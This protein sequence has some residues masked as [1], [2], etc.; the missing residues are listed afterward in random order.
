MRQIGDEVYGAIWFDP[1][2]TGSRL[3]AAEQVKKVLDDYARD[4]N[5]TLSKPAYREM[6]PGE[7]GV[8]Q[9]PRPNVLLYYGSARIVAFGSGISVVPERFSQQIGNDDL[10]K[11]RKI[12]R[13]QWARS[14]KTNPVVGL[15]SWL[16]DAECDNLVDEMGPETALKILRQKAS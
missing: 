12:T 5:V 2:E 3:F 11:L 15:K 14:Y 6:R 9:A 1:L 8:P 10:Q 13:E 16:S 7:P 4:N